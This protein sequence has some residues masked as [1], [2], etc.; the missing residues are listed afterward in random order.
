MPESCDQELGCGF[1]PT[2]P[3][4]LRA[5]VPQRNIQ[6]QFLEEGRTAGQIKNVIYVNIIWNAEIK[7]EYPKQMLEARESMKHFRMRKKF[8]LFGKSK[9]GVRRNG[10]VN[11]GLPFWNLI[12]HA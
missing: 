8:C 2:K 4:G 9:K 1:T 5:G 3:H 11:K 6:L 7:Q 10:E 12:N